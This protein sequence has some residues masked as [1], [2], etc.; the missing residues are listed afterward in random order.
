MDLDDLMFGQR[1]LLWPT[2]HQQSLD[3]SCSLGFIHRLNVAQQ[4]I[5]VDQMLG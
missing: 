4:T 2:L 1:M 5:Y 3:V